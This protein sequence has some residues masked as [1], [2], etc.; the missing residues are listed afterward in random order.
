[1][2]ARNP[3]ADYLA[4]LH[5]TQPQTLYLRDGELIVYRRPN[6]LHYQC[7]FKL[8]DGKWTRRTT[9]AASVEHAVANACNLYDEAR[10][11]QR[12][13]LAQ[14]TQNIAHIS[15]LATASLRQE[16]DKRQRKS[17][18]NDYVRIIERDFVPYLGERRLEQLTRNDI[19]QF[20]LWRDRR[21]QRTPT[22]STLNNY[23]AAWSRLVKT[24]VEHGYISEATPVVK[25]TT[26]GVKSTA[27][28]AFTAAEVDVMLASMHEWKQTS[29]HANGVE[30]RHLLCDYIEIL[31]YTGMRHGTEAMNLR[32]CD[33]E[34]HWHDGKRYLRLWVD[35]KTGGRWL[36]AKHKALPALERLQQRHAEL[37][38]MSFDE[39]LTS[40]VQKRLF[41]RHST[42]TVPKDFAGAFDALMRATGLQRDS[43]GQKRTLYSLRHTYATLELLN[44]STDIHTL[45]K[46]MGNSAAMIERHYSKLT[47]TMAAER[48]A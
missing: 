38:D 37:R 11:R 40:R 18:L 26:V 12:L 6:T 36:I 8:A 31:L 48:L 32:W 42:G 16:I 45:S 5:A 30:M 20:E 2:T 9:G 34:W 23:A 41:R 29:P 13:G 24:A 1:M 27:R 21:N 47:A 33:V 28:P 25:L 4:T 15:R 19:K 17:A 14:A 3:Y 39:L 46:Q 44:N 22:A 10:F 43:N 35:G 7:R